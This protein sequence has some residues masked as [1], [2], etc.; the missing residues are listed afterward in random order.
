[1]Q[2]TKMSWD[3]ELLLIAFGVAYLVVAWGY[4]KYMSQSLA[5][6]IGTATQRI[7]GAPKK[8]K[9]YKVIQEAARI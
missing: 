2:L 7:T 5:K 3:Y 4:E 9:Q 8:R 6:F 1:M